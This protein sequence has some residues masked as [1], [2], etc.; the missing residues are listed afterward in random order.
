MSQQDSPLLLPISEKI[1]LWTREW[2]GL[3]LRV[4]A[5]EDSRTW[6]LSTTVTSTNCFWPLYK[7]EMTSLITGHGSG[8]MIVFT[9]GSGPWRIRILM[10][11]PHMSFWS[12]LKTNQTTCTLTNTVWWFRAKQSWMIYPVEI[13]TLSC[14]MMV[15]KNLLFYFSLQF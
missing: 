5:E 10:L 1:T 4:T 3:K 7:T 8:F 9:A 12:G 11:A 14:V 15:W 6:S 2:A 13:I